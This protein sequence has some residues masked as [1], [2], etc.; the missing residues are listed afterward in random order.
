MGGALGLVFLCRVWYGNDLITAM[1][2]D[3]NDDEKRVSLKRI[4]VFELSQLG[5]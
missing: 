5:Q 3:D 1:R 2:N 4:L